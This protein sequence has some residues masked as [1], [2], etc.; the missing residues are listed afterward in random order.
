MTTTEIP[1]LPLLTLDASGLPVAPDATPLAY[2]VAGR[3]V[4]SVVQAGV[5]RFFLYVDVTD[6][7]SSQAVIVRAE[8]EV[9][10]VASSENFTILVQ[11]VTA[12]DTDTIAIAVADAWTGMLGDGPLGVTVTVIDGSAIP[13]GGITVDVLDT[14]GNR[15][16]V[17]GLTSSSGIVRF[18][19]DADDYEFTIASQPGF[20]AHTPQSLT[21]DA[22]GETL[23]LTVARQSVALPYYVPSNLG[24][25]SPPPMTLADLMSHIFTSFDLAPTP[26]DERKALKAAMEG[27]RHVTTK[28]AWRYNNRRDRVTLSAPCT[29][30]TVSITGSTVTLAGGTWPEWASLGVLIFAGDTL[31]DDRGWRVRER[32]S[33]TVLLLDAPVETDV[34]GKTYTLAQAMVMIPYQTRQIYEIYNAT[35]D[36]PI[37]II[38]HI[39]LHKHELWNDATPAELRSVAITTNHTTGEKFLA[40][41]PPPNR[42]TTI[43]IDGLF[44]A[45]PA[46]RC[47]RYASAT[48]SV[49]ISGSV[50]TFTGV[51]I[52]EGMGDMILYVGSTTTAPAPR[53][54]WGTSS[55]ELPSYTLRV[56]QRINDTSVEL[57]G[58][59]GITTSG[60]GF[61][62]ADVID[63]PKHV[64]IAIE[65]FT[66]AVFAR[67]TQRKNFMQL[68]AI[69]EEELRYAI[70]QDI[71]T[72]GA[73][74]HRR[75]QLRSGHIISEES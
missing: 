48:A 65:R 75:P 44:D 24:K 40:F 42:E 37:S 30:G 59:S 3:A 67:M 45:L 16:G 4:V 8:W 13:V 22:D 47:L 58:A 63:Y 73:T 25:S 43:T 60:K 46:E 23:T 49:A 55:T 34:A 28:H 1:P 36:Q 50:A 74:P 11:S 17:W 61:I 21:V 68:D 70:E 66:D 57:Y 29:T 26:L 69:A 19:L 20:A 52:P 39:D 33:D 12:A 64:L 9:S 71:P 14:D 7:D 53:F 10:G 6:E 32:V 31:S 5:G 56:R 62:L 51:K 41:S 54:G 18:G 72:T 38:S 15:I 2:V 27:I 35:L